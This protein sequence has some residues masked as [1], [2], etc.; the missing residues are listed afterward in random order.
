LLPGRRN[1]QREDRQHRAIHG[2][3]HAHLV[4]RDARKQRAHVV[5]RVDRNTR[6]ADIASDARVVGIVAAVR[7]EI[8]G[9]REAFLSCGKVAA[10]EGVGIFRRREAGILPNRPR[11]V[12]I[13]GRVGAAQIG[14]NP[15]PGL[16]EID[17][18]QIG[19]AISGLDRNALGVSQGSALPV[20]CALATVSNPDVGEVWY[21]AHGCHSITNWP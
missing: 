10:I 12:D 9:D 21:A 20:G 17:A 16:E 2:H 13:H 8:E 11:L 14:C 18:G 6:H 3:R 19:F 4:E 1:E 5:N 15:G 7:C